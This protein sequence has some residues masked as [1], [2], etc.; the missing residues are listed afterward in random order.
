MD[1][2]D[3]HY[4]D[5][6]LYTKWM[7]EPLRAGDVLL[8]S[9]APTGE[10]AYI[11][12]DVDWA[13]GQRLFA[14][15]GRPEILD[16][17]YLSYLLR[18]GHVRHQLMS[19]TTGTTVSGIRQSELV[20]IELD[21]P[22]VDEQRAIAAM[23]GAL[24]EKVESNRRLVELVPALLAAC[25][26]EAL[27]DES[28]RN[29]VA[30]LA[31]FVNGGAYT[32]GATGTGRMVIRIAELNSGPGGST[33]YND[34]EVP[35]TKTAR[36]G[37]I[38]M[39]W[40]GSLGVYRWALDEAIINQH[41]FKVIPSGYPA[42]FVFDRL[43]A[44]MPL[45][46]AVAKDKATTM[47]HIQRGHLESTAVAVPS[48]DALR[49]LDAKLSPVWDWLLHAEREIVRLTALRDGLMPELL[50]GGLRTGESLADLEF[51]P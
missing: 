2:N 32:K 1:D 20:K 25:V 33:V 39:S 35:E 50:S 9:E 36:A 45:F 4:V 34:I 16:G 8:T 15:R 44:V 46:Q 18:G 7:K 22:S 37:D 41:I 49:V 27:A 3:H 13:V 23:L 42:W 51:A 10:V 5:D 29:P 38:L 12:E 6:R 28:T 43:K 26:A 48:A 24:D 17:R 31:A 14:L 19:R 40:S 47:G 21:L 30:S 11:A